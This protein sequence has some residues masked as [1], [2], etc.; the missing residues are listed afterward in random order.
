MTL[1]LVLILVLATGI[2]FVTW[3]TPA[4]F[5]ACGI[6]LIAILELLHVGS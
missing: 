2:A 3:K 1:G 4:F 5:A 6:D